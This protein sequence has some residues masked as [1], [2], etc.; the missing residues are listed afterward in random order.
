MKTM[1]EVNPYKKLPSLWKATKTPLSSNRKTIFPLLLLQITQD[2]LQSKQSRNYELGSQILTFWLAIFRPVIYW[3]WQF[4]L[5]GTYKDYLKW[6]EDQLIQW[7]GR[8][9]TQGRWLLGAVPHKPWSKCRH[10]KK[11]NK[12]KKA[13]H[14]HLCIPLTSRL[15][16]TAVRNCSRL[17]TAGCW[18]QSGKLGEAFQK[19]KIYIKVWGGRGRH[20]ESSN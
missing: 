19:G 3:H 16:R 17:A 8:E 5:S 14:I 18:Q 10:K 11:K 9:S 6:W 20:P 13:T 15:M 1:T 4:P 7:Q 12:T 2:A